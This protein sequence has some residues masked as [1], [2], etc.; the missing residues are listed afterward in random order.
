MRTR[1]AEA[2]ATTRSS[3]GAWRA[4]PG[5]LRGPMGTTEL[6]SGTPTARGA[7]C[8]R[9]SWT[10]GASAP[11]RRAAGAPLT[12]ST[13]TT[14]LPSRA[15]N[16]ARDTKDSAATCGSSTGT[17]ARAAARRVG[18]ASTRYATIRW[19]S[20]LCAAASLR[21]ADSQGLRR[22]EP[23]PS[24]TGAP[25]ARATSSRRYVRS[26]MSARTTTIPRPSTR[27]AMSPR[28]A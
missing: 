16:T 1:S 13:R 23:T 24:L 26:D 27:P 15:Q 4:T 10:P 7:S 25:S 6:G 5:Q 3:G 14:R 28:A 2:Q 18:T 9:T 12:R 20:V 21:L 19:T 22:T 17:T 8:T 11:T